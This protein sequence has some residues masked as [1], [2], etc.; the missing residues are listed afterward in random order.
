MGRPAH[1]G[2]DLRQPAA[3]PVRR[4]PRPGW[5]PAP[6]LRLRAGAG[7][8]REQHLD[9]VHLPG[10]PG[11]LRAAGQADGPRRLGSRRRG[12]GDG[13]R[14]THRLRLAAAASPRGGLTDKRQ[15]A[16][17]RGQ[18]SVQR[19][20]KCHVELG[21]CTPRGCWSWL[22]PCNASLRRSWRHALRRMR[23]RMHG[24]R[25]SHYYIAPAIITWTA[26]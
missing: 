8:D 5:R 3:Q 2:L 12:R 21:F 24:D 13:D 23:W 17:R 20:R 9:D 22:A 19:D 16:E 6:R 11:W 14:G 7:H 4:D 26:H 25:P 15:A 1:P 18:R 10:Q